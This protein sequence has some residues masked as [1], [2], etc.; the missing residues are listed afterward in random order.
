MQKTIFTLKLLPSSINSIACILTITLLVLSACSDPISVTNEGPAKNKP[1]NEQ[2]RAFEIIEINYD[3]IYK[4][5][6]T[7]PTNYIS[8]N[9]NIKSH[10]HW[11]FQM[12]TDDLKNY[13]ASGFEMIEIGK[14]DKHIHHQLDDIYAL[15][16]FLETK[17]QKV[18]MTFGSG[19]MEAII[20]ES[21]IEYSIEPL[22][23]YNKNANPNQYVLYSGL[24]ILDCDFNCSDE[25]SLSISSVE[26]QNL[27]KAPW[28]IKLTYL[29]DY[30]FYQKFKTTADAFNYM[31]WRFYYANKRF[32][33]FN[34]V[35]LSWNLQTAYLYT[36]HGSRNYNPKT[37][38]NKSTFAKEC[39]AYYDYDWYKSGD[40]NFFFTGDDV[41]GVIGR[42]IC[43]GSMCN[44]PSKAFSF[45]EWRPSG[46]QASNLMAH[47][48]GHVMGCPH[49]ESTNN[50]MHESVSKWRSI[51]G[52]EAKSKLLS[53]LE[54]NSCLTK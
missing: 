28:Q 26:N 22:S 32:K 2:L 51:L 9:L 1:L 23:N 3:Q 50:F 52:D 24:D 6:T 29:G 20:V 49:D 43:L 37:R 5:A 7:K 35:G 45:S 17:N 21:D 47:E 4:I 36:S 25:S 53:C 40:V 41:E 38:S 16:G 33:A 44:K 8:L 15:E 39:S 14:M 30:Q 54:K 10:P 31:F 12:K 48:I 11:N 42:S 18:V 19:K 34:D 46:Y 13:I 27:N